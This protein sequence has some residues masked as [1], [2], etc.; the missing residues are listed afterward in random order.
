MTS[1]ILQ[2]YSLKGIH[3]D[4]EFDSLT[5]SYDTQSVLINTEVYTFTQIRVNIHTYGV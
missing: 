5:S 4:Q 1:S 3:S 2:Q